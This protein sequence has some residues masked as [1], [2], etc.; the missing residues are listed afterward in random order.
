MKYF[1]QVKAIIAGLMLSSLVVP[2]VSASDTEIYTTLP[3]GSSVSNPNIMFVVD[4]SV[5]MEASSDVKPF[6]DKSV[7]YVVPAGEFPCETTGVYMVEEDSANAF[8]DCSNENYFNESA[9]VCDHAIIGYKADGTKESPAEDGGLWMVGTYSDQLAHYDTTAERWLELT[10]ITNSVQQDYKVECLSDSGIHGDNGDTSA[11]Y[12]QDGGTGFT[13]TAPANLDVP[14]PVWVGS[15]GHAQLFSGNYLNYLKATQDTLTFVN[16]QYIDQVKAAVEVMVRGNTQV[17][18]GLMRLDKMSSNGSS[19]NSEGGAVLYPIRDVGADRNDFFTRLATLDSDGYSPLS[20]TYYEAL[21]YFG[22]RATDYSNSSTPSNQIVNLTQKSNG[23][24]RSPISSTCDKNYIV[25]LSAGTPT[26]DVVNTARQAVLPEF[27]GSCSTNIETVQVPGGGANTRDAYNAVDNCL[28]ELATWAATKDVAT[29]VNIPAHDGTQNVFTHTI[30]IGLVPGTVEAPNADA[31][32]AIALL[33]NTAQ[34]GKGTFYQA[35]DQG[36]LV[37]IFNKIIENVLEV[38]STFSS[39]AVSVNAFNRSTHL[40]DLYFTLF[41]PGV[42][43]H[44]DGN[45]KKYKL[46][47]EVDTNDKD[48]DGDTTERLPFI[49]GQNDVSA[50]DPGTGFFIDAVKSYWT[51]VDDPNDGSEVTDGGAASVLTTSRNVLTYTGAYTGAASGV[52]VPATPNLKDAT[53]IVINTNDSLTDGLLSTPAAPEIVAGTS[54]RLTLINWASGLDALSQYGDVNTYDDVRSQMG[55]P[56]HSELALVQYGET[57][58]TVDGVTTVTADLVAYVATNDGYLHA[59][60]VSTGAE[61]FS[62]IP[63]E[64]LPKLPGIMLNSGGDKSYGLDGSVVAWINDINKDGDVADTGEHVY[65]YVS[66][67]RGGNNIYALNVTNR[68]SPELMWVIKGGTGNYAQLGQTWSTINVEKIKDGADERT[69][70]IFGGGYDDAQ[71]AAGSPRATDSVGKT[72]YIADA[73]SGERLWTAGA[74]ADTPLANMDYSIPARIKPLDVSGDGYIDRLYAADM[75]GQIFRFDIDNTNDTALSSSIIGSR[76]AEFAITDTAPTVTNARRF[77]YP[78]DVALV[79]GPN[80]KYHA[81]VIA[82]GYRAH[83]LNDAIHDRIYMLKDENTGLITDVANYPALLTESSLLNVTSNLAGGEGVTAGGTTVVDEL[84]A[85]NSRNG[86]YIKLD[87][88]T[89]TDAWIGEKGLSEPLILE[90]TAIVTTYTPNLTPDPNSCEP[91]TGVGKIYF[92]DILD[93]TAAFPSSID[94]RGDRVQQLARGGIPPTPNVIITEGGEP[95][96]CVGTECG[97]AE[98]GLGVRKTYWYEEEK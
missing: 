92:L 46:R 95:T 94:S 17:D 18:I 86:W 31:D 76:I 78:P 72:V 9:L 2:V 42:G 1:N 5:N 69:V 87:D 40:D 12:I 39:P 29:D 62:F 47:F 89:N 55:D 79:D 83:P 75:G 23:E 53:N 68:E 19:G 28:D 85:I 41:K 58:T 6:Y 64:L 43:N 13:S 73:A 10:D 36:D 98:F 3:P 90:G 26:L 65:L 54:N 81:M 52:N 11:S 84:D 27:T 96:L 59:I 15:A 61:L 74:D 60:N 51:P 97:A 21:L 63:Q 44:W 37:A 22:G 91:A 93:G 32:A 57:S 16:M 20:E 38:N 80:G 35:S 25:L 67:R 14:H 30:G 82:S 66:M 4:T 50:I 77:Y 49:A 24:F 48:G 88:G 71:D 70:L 33:H 34:N 45:L 56:L 7:T 8:P